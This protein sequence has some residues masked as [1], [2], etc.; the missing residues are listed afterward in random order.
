[1]LAQQGNHRL[2]TAT[3]ERILRLAQ[4]QQSEVQQ[5]G[6]EED[7]EEKE[8][9]QGLESTSTKSHQVNFVCLDHWFG[10]AASSWAMVDARAALDVVPNWSFDDRHRSSSAAASE[11]ERGGVA[12]AAVGSLSCGGDV[13]SYTSVMTYQEKVQLADN[14]KS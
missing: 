6:N 5:K 3:Y 11:G 1:V 14:I 7:E 10:Y 12:A 9:H 8:E 4:E 13:G 2:A